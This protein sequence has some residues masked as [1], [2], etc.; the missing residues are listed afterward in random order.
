MGQYISLYLENKQNNYENIGLRE[1][2]E[3]I[4]HAENK[5]KQAL[6][7]K[8]AYKYGKKVINARLNKWHLTAID[9][10]VYADK[11]KRLYNSYEKSFKAV[12]KIHK[13][14]GKKFFLLYS[15][16]LIHTLII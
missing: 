10:L 5:H 16:Y 3:Y 8:D 7:S 14:K 1:I 2:I 4:G 12:W 13:N 9:K 15:V 11:E 6:S